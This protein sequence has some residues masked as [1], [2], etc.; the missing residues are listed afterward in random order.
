ML[1]IQVNRGLLSSGIMASYLIYLCWSAIRSEPAI[2][3]C[4]P[5]SEADGNGDWTT[6]LGF[7]IAI[8]AIVEATFS[9]GKDSQ[10]FQFRKD[11]IQWE[12]DIPYKYE[13]FHII[14]SMGA[15]YFA[16]LF[17]NWQLDHS[18]R[19]WSIDVG[20][21][22]T[23]VKIVNEWLAASIYCKLFTNCNLSFLSFGL[24]FRC[25]WRSREGLWKLISPTVRQNHIGDDEDPI[26]HI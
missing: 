19:K 23:W 18:T 17:I 16:M 1:K 24:F 5:Q 3:I 7:L 6:V 22:S 11:D 2:A 21:A 12:D 25:T 10:T 14:F 13:F 8:C 26:H 9:T 20:W 4:S 15:M